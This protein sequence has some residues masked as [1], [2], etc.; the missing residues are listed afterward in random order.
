M[1]SMKIIRHHVPLIRFKY[2]AN[3]FGSVTRASTENKSDSHVSQ[4]IGASSQPKVGQKSAALEFSQTPK[5]Y[6]RRPLTQDEI[7]LIAVGGFT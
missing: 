5:K 1:A 7:D 4:T 3:Q 6:R 2:G